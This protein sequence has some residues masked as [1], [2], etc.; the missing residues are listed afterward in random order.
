MPSATYRLAHP[1]KK[2]N[3]NGENDCEIGIFTAPVNSYRRTRIS[4]TDPLFCKAMNRSA[5]IFERL[6][7]RLK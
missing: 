1:H 6:H 3:K 7:R 5:A 2:A 4:P